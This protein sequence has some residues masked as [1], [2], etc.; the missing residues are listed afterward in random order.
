MDGHWPHVSGTALSAYAAGGMSSWHESARLSEAQEKLTKCISVWIRAGSVAKDLDA[1]AP[2]LTMATSTSV[3]FCTDDRNP[4]DIARE[5]HVDHLVRSAIRKGV[6]PEVAYR[7][8]SW[9]VARH[10][11]LAG[12]AR[13]GTRVR[14]IAPG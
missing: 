10:Y 14:A 9:T 5:G 1:L 3:G 6:T 2:L 8:A 13:N 11:G 7:A 4:L 12:P